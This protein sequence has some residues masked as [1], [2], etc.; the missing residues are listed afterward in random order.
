MSGIKASGDMRATEVR[1]P[2]CLDAFVPM[3]PIVFLPNEEKS[4]VVKNAKCYM[5]ASGAASC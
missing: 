1:C 2:R 5:E 4:N 3:V